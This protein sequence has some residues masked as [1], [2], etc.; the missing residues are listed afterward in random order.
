ME[1]TQGASASAILSL[2]PTSTLSLF[3]R[4]EAKDLCSVA[5]VC[6]EWRR[7]TNDITLWRD[8][9]Y[10]NPLPMVDSHLPLLFAR[11]PQLPLPEAC[12]VLDFDTPSSRQLALL[13]RPLAPLNSSPL[14]YAE[15][16]ATHQGE[17]TKEG[18]GS[19]LPALS[20]A[21]EVSQLGGPR[22]G[23][24]GG[25]VRHVS[26]AS[27][28]EMNSVS[29]AWRR[30]R[31]SATRLSLPGSDKA[32]SVRIEALQQQ[33]V[34]ASGASGACTVINLRTGQL[35]EGIG[36]AG[37][38]DVLSYPSDDDL[39][40]L[41]AC[42]A[43]SGDARS[44]AYGAFDGQVLLY[45]VV[46][47]RLSASFGGLQHRA[48]AQSLALSWD[49]TCVAA[50]LSD[51]HLALGRGPRH[52]DVI[53][54][55]QAEGVGAT[56]GA[57][58]SDWWMVRQLGAGLAVTCVEANLAGS[59]A[60]G[61]EQN[62][63]VVGT[64]GGHVMVLD[65]ET[66][67]KRSAFVGSCSC[68]VACLCLHARIPPL[69][70]NSFHPEI[71]LAEAVESCLDSGISWQQ[72]TGR[73]S[74]N[75]LRSKSNSS[76]SNSDSK[77]SSSSSSLS[78]ERLVY[79][80]FHH[81][82]TGNGHSNAV[83]VWDMS[84]SERV[85][86]LYPGGAG[87]A[88][89][90]RNGRGGGGYLGGGT[91]ATG[92]IKAVFADGYKVV[93]T[94]GKSAT[95]FETRKWEVLYEM[96]VAHWSSAKTGERGQEGSNKQEEEEREGRHGDTDWFWNIADN[97][98][99]GNGSHVTAEAVESCMSP[100]PMEGLLVPLDGGHHY[101]YQHAATG[102]TANDGEDSG[103]DDDNDSSSD[104]DVM[105]DGVRDSVYDGAVVDMGSKSSEDQAP[106]IGASPMGEGPND[107]EPQVSQSA[108][109]SGFA[110]TG[111]PPKVAQT[112]RQSSMAGRCP[113]PG[114][115]E[116]GPVATQ[117]SSAS[118]AMRVPRP[119]SAAAIGR[120]PRQANAPGS[121]LT[122]AFTLPDPSSSQNPFGRSRAL[123][124]SN[125]RPDPSPHAGPSS[126]SLTISPEP[127]QNPHTV[128]S[129]HRSKS[130][131]PSVHNGGA[132]LPSRGGMWTLSRSTSE[133]EL[134]VKRGAHSAGPSASGGR[135]MVIDDPAP[136]RIHFAGNQLVLP[137]EGGAVGLVTMGRF[138]KGANES[139][140]EAA[141]LYV[142]GKGAKL[143][144]STS[145]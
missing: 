104:N 6:R 29:E 10:R 14:S 111:L 129:S 36:L 95:V 135:W 59:A 17:D 57:V 42:T 93:V 107:T 83:F 51:G 65:G 73:F 92:A 3:S 41:Y 53:A 82:T 56:S 69:R 48:A 103:D 128:L 16:S 85:A 44:V 134:D 102:R 52:P 105:N 1:T 101:A 58:A 71:V 68:P 38:Q 66:G 137:L 4:L 37:N 110:A 106:S 26:H 61:A 99:G 5:M 122:S 75:S 77:D 24:D 72:R 94:A 90:T 124:A 123:L 116:R 23:P 91:S 25:L 131:S 80:A 118:A 33:L 88:R 62:L 96:S 43:I 89:Q 144:T 141:E 112:L 28:K 143:T 136:Q 70:S 9:W 98:G 8:L 81:Q 55:S 67:Q 31:G 108:S 130:V 114:R 115:D 139:T 30:G 145:N 12:R 22:K 119:S 76:S 133:G 7:I 46:S 97:V 50:G 13:P 117:E 126:S 142:T 74:N 60:D 121:S 84:S 45:D 49:A 132:A 78:G 100:R 39:H 64:S 63:I 11:P 86:L 40:G 27:W 125:A 140:D 138:P 15:S 2:D 87:G 19:I 35:C 20:S 32:S 54:M 34:V 109:W 120:P 47:G 18:T 21:E 127:F 79:A 113:S